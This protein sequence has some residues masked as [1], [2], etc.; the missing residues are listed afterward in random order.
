MMLLG[1][2]Q[3]LS[4]RRPSSDPALT[5]TAPKRVVSLKIA[6]RS[7]SP[8][9]A[10]RFLSLKT[11]AR[12]VSLR[13]TARFLS[14]KVITMPYVGD[15]SP[16][17]SGELLSL[18]FDFSSWIPSG[19]SIASCSG[20]VTAYE[21]VD[22]SAAAL[23]VGAPVAS[24]TVVSQWVGPAFVPGVVY[25]LYLSVTTAFGSKLTAFGHIA[26]LNAAAPA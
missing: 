3:L 24:G 14:R 18:S 22:P 12:S 15:F 9:A 8:R 5:I 16:C 19:D 1:L 10:A 13:A 7:V 23:A 21:G 11:A 20:A 4:R 26:C 25:R 6:G 17:D 2:F